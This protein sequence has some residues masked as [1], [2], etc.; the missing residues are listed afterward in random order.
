VEFIATTTGKT[1]NSGG[2]GTGKDFNE[3]EFSGSSGE[4]TFSSSTN[5]VTSTVNVASVG[6]IFNAGSTF[7]FTNIVW[8]GQATTTR[9]T[10]RSSSIG[11]RWNL[12]VTGNQSVLNVDAQDSNA[13]S[14]D[15]IDA[16]NTSNYNSGN[17]NCWLFTISVSNENVLRLGGD[18]HTFYNGSYYWMFYLNEDGEVVYSTSMA[19]IFIAVIPTTLILMKGK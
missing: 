10:L 4:W 15:N 12:I 1:I 14:G 6:L 11:T 19:Q 5:A 16:T 13:C 9:L 7:I 18:R 3:I 8:D 17:N 2:T